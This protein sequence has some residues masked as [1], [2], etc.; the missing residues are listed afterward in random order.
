MEKEGIVVQAL[1]TV[2]S[3]IFFGLIFMQCATT[4]KVYTE[5]PPLQEATAKS[6]DVQRNLPRRTTD[7]L[8]YLIENN[9]ILKTHFVGFVLHDLEEQ[10]DILSINGSR[11]FTP[12]SNMKLYTLYTALNY[13][14][15]TTTALE[16]RTSGDS[17]IVRATGDPSFLDPYQKNNET[18]YTFL[19]EASEDIYL[20]VSL[21]DDL[22]YGEGWAWDDFPYYYQAEK[23]AFPIYANKFYLRKETYDS[24]L[25]IFPQYFSQFASETLDSTSSSIQ[26]IAHTNDFL[27]NTEKIVDK[28]IYRDMPFTSSPELVVEL[29]ADTLNREV[30]LYTGSSS[31]QEFNQLKGLSTDSLLQEMMIISD[32]FIAE[33]LLLMCSY[34]KLGYMNTGDLIKLAKEE[35]FAE[36]P[37]EVRWVDG[38]GL[39]RYNLI[40]PNDNIWVLKKI[41]EFWNLEKIKTYFPSGKGNDTLDDSFQYEKPWL[42]AKTGSLS[43]NFNL[44]GYLI[45]RSNKVLIFSFM[46]NHY[47]K[48]RSQVIQEMNSILSFVRDNY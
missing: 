1:K 16:Y 26:R 13:L 4:K 12:A 19:N 23:S 36:L 39:S 14:D 15:D 34:H 9:P 47:M 21:F 24:T 35:L 31:N 33:Q 45:T 18:A 5:A 44:S 25:Q 6:I 29:L 20:D 22:P 40:S 3:T 46:N 41:L 32:N 28:K 17:M 43:N 38:S 11:T 10:Q 42:F 7:S 27:I 8:S 2:V 48:K 30:K 37:D